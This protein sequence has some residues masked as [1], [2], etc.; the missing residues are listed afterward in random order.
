MF[1]KTTNKHVHIYDSSTNDLP[2]GQYNMSE[3]IPERSTAQKSHSNFA[4]SVMTPQ[5]IPIAKPSER[6]FIPISLQ[7]SLHESLTQSLGKGASTDNFGSLCER[8]LQFELQ[9]HSDPGRATKT[10]LH[11]I[12]EIAQTEKSKGFIQPSELHAILTGIGISMS[13]KEVEILCT[14][15]ASNGTGGIDALELGRV[16]Q[17]MTYNTPNNPIDR[18]LDSKKLIDE[19]IHNILE[20]IAG[21]IV[22]GKQ[23][24]TLSQ[25]RESLTMIK[26]KSNEEKQKYFSKIYPEIIKSIS[27]PFLR[28]D[29][30]ENCIILIKGFQ[31]IIHLMSQNISN[32]EIKLLCEYYSVQ[33]SNNHDHHEQEYS[34]SYSPGKRG[35]EYQDFIKDLT[36][37]IIELLLGGHHQTTNELLLHPPNSS[38]DVLPDISPSMPWLLR[39][40]D[41]IDDLFNQLESMKPSIQRKILIQLQ[42]S[43][44]DQENQSGE[45]GYLDGYSVLKSLLS[46]GFNISRDLRIKF[47]NNIEKYSG[48]FNYFD[49]CT[50]L[51]TSCIDW[52]SQERLVL[53]KLFFHYKLNP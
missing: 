4:W 20:N 45:E 37:A 8:R 32:D 52:T 42:M 24:G 30:N 31:K 19:A 44:K 25:L 28:I 40:F 12:S 48:Y 3:T 27:K 49:L 10:L 23:F 29:S 16:I 5:S 51:S 1:L 2:L 38:K 15:F 46:V 43:L 21:D 36:Y 53:G 14:G 9:N 33:E 22:T 35:I 34:N 13:I 17:T 6:E 7:S 39:E 18:E 41:F 50:I 11:E 26:I 47:L